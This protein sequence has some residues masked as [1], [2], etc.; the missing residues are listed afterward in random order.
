MVPRMELMTRWFS[1]VYL[2]L[3]ITMFLVF[4]FTLSGIFFSLGRLL[5]C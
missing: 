3:R 5:S 4:T 2:I 1:A